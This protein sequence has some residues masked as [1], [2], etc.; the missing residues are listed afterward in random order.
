[1][2]LFSTIIPW[3]KSLPTLWHDGWARWFLPEKKAT[4]QIFTLFNS[5]LNNNS[6]HTLTFRLEIWI[7]AFVTQNS[8]LKVSPRWLPR[9]GT[10]LRRIFFH[11]KSL[12]WTRSP[13][14]LQ[15]PIWPS[16]AKSWR[17]Q[18][19]SSYISHHWALQ[20]PP[21]W[22]QVSAPVP[23]IHGIVPRGSMH[24]PLVFTCDSNNFRAEFK[25][26]SSIKSCMHL[27]GKRQ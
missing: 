13:F 20:T 16:S 23:V 4:K 12:S 11:L 10:C 19:L 7:Y 8:C 6:Y 27:H 3:P 2:L 17:A 1:M 15:S 24:G 9:K 18:W 22:Y 25:L 21:I 5:D 26:V 14:S